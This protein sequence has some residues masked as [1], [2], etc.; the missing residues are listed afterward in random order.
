MATRLAWLLNFD[1]DLE[2]QDPSRYRPAKAVL[3]R[4]ASLRAQL[5]D[6][7]DPGDVV[8]EVDGLDPPPSN[9][10]VQTFCP[11]PSALGRI[12]ALGLLPPAAP[13]LDVL[14][15]VNDR[16]FC[17]QLGHGLEGSCFAE[18]L[19]ALEAQL[20]LPSFSSSYVIKRAFSFAGREQ[21]RVHNGVLDDSTRG[22][23]LRSFAQREGLQ[24]EPWVTRLL[25]FSRHGYLTRAGAVLMGATREQRCD[26]MGRFLGMS[27]TSPALDPDEERSV[28]SALQQTATALSGAGYFGPFGIDGF[29]YLD[30]AGRPALDPRCEINAR[31]T[32]GYPRDLLL[33]GLALD[34]NEAP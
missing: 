34:A 20:R 6:L 23:C 4:A 21:R 2:L 9:L 10:T 28:T 19:A 15:R 8:L 11:T 32:M 17:A 1:A 14:R 33:E 26:P 7:I 22:F 16:R 3:A 30:A 27:T 5:T 12:R 29:R 31:L 13:S 18:D 25:D 24:I